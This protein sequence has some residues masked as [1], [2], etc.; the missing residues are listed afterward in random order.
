MSA[1]RLTQLGAVIDG[2]VGSLAR[3]RRHQ[4]GGIAYERHA[5]NAF[6]TVVDRQSMNEPHYGRGIAV[7]DQSTE[8]RRPTL[9][10]V[11]NALQCGRRLAEVEVAVKSAQFCV[12]EAGRAVVMS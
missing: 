11:C 7:G 4:M 3:E 2:Q 1:E 6:P 12:L 8:L 10:F 5:A 9:E